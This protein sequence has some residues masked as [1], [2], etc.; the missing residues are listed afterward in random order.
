MCVQLLSCFH[1]PESSFL[2]AHFTNQEIRVREGRWYRFSLG[3]ANAH[4]IAVFFCIFAFCYI[5]FH[6]FSTIHTF[7]TKCS[8]GT[9]VYY[10]SLWGKNCFTH[11]G[12]PR[13]YAAK[14]SLCPMLFA[15]TGMLFILVSASQ[16]CRPLGSQGAF[17]FV[18][19]GGIFLLVR[20]LLC[21]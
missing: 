15:Y 3:D 20:V 11:L 14:I 12:I 9:W 10:T 17:P 16:L 18:G 13:S 1:K 19:C 2:S 7:S 8:N 4:C 21:Y 5:F 6:T